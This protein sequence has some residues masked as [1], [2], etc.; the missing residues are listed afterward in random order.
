MW[1]TDAM[2]FLETSDAHSLIG[3]AQ[4]VVFSVKYLS[5]Q[6]WASEE[7]IHRGS[8]PPR[9]RRVIAILLLIRVE[10]MH[11]VTS[12]TKDISFLNLR[13]VRQFDW[14]NNNFV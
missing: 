8:S 10:W 2:L 12:I 1:V 7:F 9:V 11:G 3:Q 4:L 14:K 13:N 5:A 6:L